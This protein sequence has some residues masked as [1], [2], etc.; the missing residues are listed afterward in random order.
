MRE[1]IITGCVTT[2]ASSL[3]WRRHLFLALALN[4]THGDTVGCNAVGMFHK[5]QVRTLLRG[6]SRESPG[7]T[8][9]SFMARLSRIFWFAQ[10]ATPNA[11][12][13]T[14]C[15]CPPDDMPD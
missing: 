3:R 1:S 13:T 14:V 15:A 8:M 10:V 6:S 9:T 12:D 7:H 5:V 2:T 4:V 11:G